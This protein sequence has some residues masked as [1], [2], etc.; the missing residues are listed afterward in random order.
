MSTNHST[1]PAPSAS[2]PNPAEEM[3]AHPNPSAAGTAE[4]ALPH[5]YGVHTQ[6]LVG[7]PP[8]PIYLGA[9]NTLPPALPPALPPRGRAAPLETEGGRPLQGL[10]GLSGLS[11]LPHRSPRTAHSPRTPRTH[12]PSPA[13]TGAGSPS[14]SSPTS[15]STREAY[16]PAALLRHLVLLLALLLG[17]TLWLGGYRPG[18]SDARLG[19]SHGSIS[20]IK[21]TDG[22]TGAHSLDPHDEG[23][24]PAPDTPPVSSSLSNGMSGSLGT[25]DHPVDHWETFFEGSGPGGASVRPGPGGC[26]A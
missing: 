24:R 21:G 23:V 7:L 12:L 22:D 14:P 4:A 19:W 18:L 15:P 26:A 8:M 17:L 9:Q 5:A 20:V 1:R 11:G 6:Q 10:S 13:S 2:S 16:D 25:T 3:N